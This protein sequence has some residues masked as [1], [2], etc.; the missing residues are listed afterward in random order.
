M[1]YVKDPSEKKDYAI[2]WTARL[3]DGDTITASSWTVETGLDQATPVPSFTDTVATIWLEAG[4]VGNE[5]TVTN[6]VTTAQ[7]RTHERS[8]V[9]NVQDL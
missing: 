4:E 6:T 1:S 8:F 5:Y 7:G 3:T 9:I 2:D